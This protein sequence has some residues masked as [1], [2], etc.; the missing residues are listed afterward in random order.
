MA[1][2]S[3]CSSTDYYFTKAG[4]D[5]NDGL[6]WE[7][8]KLDLQAFVQ[9][10]LDK[11]PTTV[12]IGEG[13][14]ATTN[15][16]LRVYTNVWLIG[17]NVSG[18]IISGSPPNAVVRVFGTNV[19]LEALTITGGSNSA[20][21]YGG[22][23]Y[24]LPDTIITNCV[25]TNNNNAG[26]GGSSIGGG[27]LNGS[28]YNSII[29]N[30]RTG[31]R[32]G[33]I[34]SG[35]VYNSTIAGNYAGGFGGGTENSTN[36]NC[37]IS[38]NYANASAVNTGGGTYY[39]MNS[40][41]IITMN[42]ATNSSSG[43]GSAYGFHYNCIFSYNV[44]GRSAGAAIAAWMTNCF[45]FGNSNLVQDAGA[46]RYSTNINCTITN[47]TGYDGI[48]DRGI[49]INCLISNNFSQSPN[50]LGTVYLSI[51]SNSIIINNTNRNLG[52]GASLSTLYSSLIANNNST[53]Y[54]GGGAYNSTAILCIFS[55]NS[56]QRG[57]GT[58]LGISSNCLYIENRATNT[59]AGFGGGTYN[60]SAY[61]CIFSNN[62]AKYTGGAGYFDV[63]GARLV[64]CVFDNNVALTNYSALYGAMS[65]Y[66][67][68]IL[69][70]TSSAIVVQMY[71]NIR[72]AANCI[73]Y[74]NLDTGGGIN[75]KIYQGRK[76]H[77]VDWNPLIDS[78]TYLIA[79]NSPCIGKANTNHVWSDVDLY[80][81]PRTNNGAVDVGA[82]QYWESTNVF[83][84]G[85]TGTIGAVPWW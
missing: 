42:L 66:N 81:R 67:C 16:E 48:I 37:I 31:G 69:N 75:D 79:S 50:N 85:P 54:F 30:N 28:I 24:A 29:I 34:C 26:A 60:S 61:G 64:N 11:T 27:I 25:V 20:S 4:N 45:I 52:A 12:N 55:N 40:N 3:V 56:A 49:L 83:V 77:I 47:N 15:T 38:N 39:G 13:V 8:A 46:L 1:F 10:K 18:V 80:G 53:N 23:I 58:Y 59:T 74:G 35:M 36:I 72:T 14:W 7:T 63:G 78:N 6:T 9:S 19:W 41:C 62:W 51:V 2:T 82:V 17:T 32:G 5:G 65:L 33:G 68:N 71:D 44:S 84:Y 43:G 76:T 73:V 57:G 21:V 22:G 70:H